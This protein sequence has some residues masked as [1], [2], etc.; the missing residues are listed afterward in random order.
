MLVARTGPDAGYRRGRVAVGFNNGLGTLTFSTGQ[1]A[2]ICMVAPRVAA[3]WI[4]AGKLAGYRLPLSRDRRVLRADLVR[5]MRENGLPMARLE[6]V[7]PRALLVGLEPHAAGQLTAAL[8]AQE[9][10]VT[11]LAATPAEAGLAA[12]AGVALAV[13]DCAIGRREALDLAGFLRG[14]PEPPRVVI[15]A[16]ED[17]TDEAGLAAAADHVYRKPANLEGVAGA[18]ARE[19]LR[20]AGPAGEGEEAA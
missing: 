15:L 5:F 4:D 16:N 7:S 11:T 14:L 2:R 1:V 9:G 18:F 3:R 19:P 6:E 12:A 20:L 10:W 13:I 17:E 8:A